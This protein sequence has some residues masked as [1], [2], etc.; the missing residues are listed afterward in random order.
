[1]NLKNLIGFF[2][3]F[4]LFPVIS[5]TSPQINITEDTVHDQHVANVTDEYLLGPG[6]ALDITYFFGVKQSDKEYV[7]QIGDIIDIEFYYHPDNNKR[8]TIL[9]DGKIT[10]ARKG[11]IQAAGFTISQLRH[12]ITQ[13]Y[14]DTFIDPIVT[15]NLKEFNQALNKFRDAILSERLGQS[16]LILV[17]PDGFI[18]LP[19][20]EGNI[21]AAGLSLPQINVIISKKYRQKF[22]SL[23]VSLELVN[24]NSFLV[25]ISG[26]VLRPNSYKLIGP[27]T[28]SQILSQAGL[29]WDTAELSSIIVVS[30]SPEGK[31]VGRVVDLTKVIGEGNIGNDILLK[32]FDLVYV[33]KNR[34]TKVNLWVS[35]YLSNIVPD[36]VR[37]N[38]TYSLGGKSDILD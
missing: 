18:T 30:R 29:N 38:F 10:L 25:Y 1:M 2:L 28:V 15:I 36:W 16:K 26:E 34:I 21:K 23:S 27:T 12:K 35:Q 31:A 22:D 33:P 19:Q 13:L 9:P 37:F 7:L 5:C 6:D 17:Q 24:T 8:V 32:R 4:I 3:F 20:I 14:S 11:D